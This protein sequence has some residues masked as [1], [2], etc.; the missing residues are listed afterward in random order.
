MSNEAIAWAYRQDIRNSS[1]KFV[2]VVLA[3]F[4][5]EEWSCY[6]GQ[7]RIGCM[8][9]MAER[10]VRRSLD[11]LEEHGYI[12]R[13]ARHAEH[14][15]RTSDRYWLLHAA[16]M[17]GG[18]DQEEHHET[19]GGDHRSNGPVGPAANL[20]TGQNGRLF[21]DQVSA[22]GQNDHR[23]NSP[24]SP[25]N[26][27]GLEPSVEPSVSSLEKKRAAKSKA[28]EVELPEGFTLSDGMRAWAAQNVP[29]VD[30]EFETAQFID[31]WTSRETRRKDWTGTWRQWMRNQQKWS[32]DRT[33]PAA[34]GR[35]SNVDV[36][37]QA[38][39]RDQQGG[40]Q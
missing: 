12:T 23:S 2:L 20:T 13:S 22:T 21:D 14:G 33:R 19:A 8:T 10:T 34:G 15:R 6:P 17:A 36:W 30:P 25:A 24:T 9:G 18:G 1:A 37:D 32:Q 4:A 29:E 40:F 38:A 16:K 5:D 3:D 26:L 27:S 35:G 28:A 7:K 11:W 31:Y 39:A